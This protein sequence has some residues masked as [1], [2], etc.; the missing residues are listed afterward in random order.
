[1][2]FF[3]TFFSHTIHLYFYFIF[4]RAN[5]D[6]CFCSIFTISH[7][8]MYRFR[9]VSKK[10][11]IIW[12]TERKSSQLIWKQTNTKFAI[13]DR[14]PE[15]RNKCGYDYGRA[16]WKKKYIYRCRQYGDRDIGF[17]SSDGLFC[18]VL[19]STLFY[20][21]SFFSISIFGSLLITMRKK[22]QLPFWASFSRWPLLH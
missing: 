13:I 9:L 3:S 16:E 10:K 14:V 22:S 17:I 8:S 15:K 18:F 20:L 4:I 11:N 12:W 2:I 21:F 6:V 5:K 19:N 7:H 1:M